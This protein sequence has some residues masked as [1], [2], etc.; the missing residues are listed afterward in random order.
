MTQYNFA[1]SPCPNDTF[2]FEAIV[3]NRIELRGY[4]FNIAL[5]DVAQ[6]N[7]SAIES[8]YDITKI[9]YNAYSLVSDTYQLLKSGS[10]LGHN[11]GPLLI[12]KKP[13]R[14]EDLSKYT[15][16]IPGKNTTANLLLTLAFPELTQKKEYIFSE[17]ENA[18][19]RD[20]VD[21][22]LIIHENRFTYESKGLVKVQDLGEYWES[23]TQ[24]PIP[25]GGI[26][27]R[28][29]LPEKVKQDIEDILS[30]SIQF[31]FDNRDVVQDYISSH[32]QEMDEKVM[33]SHIDLYVNGQS[34]LLDK[35]AKKGIETLLGTIKSLYPE[36]NVNEKI[37]V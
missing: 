37:F 5:A 11:C 19:V 7:H 6:L 20:E 29:D 14:H 32:A 13:I 33:Q 2:M 8:K 31:A 26:A 10:A 22:G 1:F 25:L 12:S 17:V 15:V 21:L 36:R 9:S 16:A 18:L 27:I 23:T 30:E 3:N 35:Q 24:C 34:V 28:R 4:E